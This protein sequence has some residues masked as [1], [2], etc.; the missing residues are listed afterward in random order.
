MP[1]LS[2]SIDL[3][4]VV[5]EVAL[6]I[7][8]LSRRL[9]SRF[10][11]FFTYLLLSTIGD[12]SALVWSWN[13][14]EFY[15]LYLVRETV[16]RALSLLVV[17]SIFS[18][19][20]R[21]VL[22]KLGKIGTSLSFLSLL[23]LDFLFWRFYHRALRPTPLGRMAVGVYTFELCV[24]VLEVAVCL[25]C[26]WLRRRYG[27][28]GEYDL[29]IIIGFGTMSM[30][31]IAAYGLPF[32]FGRRFDLWFQLIPAASFIGATISWLMTFS[33]PEAPPKEPPNPE[34]LR[35]IIEIIGHWTREVES[36]VGR[37][38]MRVDSLS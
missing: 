1:N 4:A 25:V 16:T 24:S 2:L 19:A 35:E 38:G 32:L 9:Q 21:F 31:T 12:L 8:L 36:V 28:W 27:V 15:V 26:L 13:V 20:L 5:L 10:A 29:G 22:Y 33:Q 6:A 7:V 14:T 3:T 37:L 30:G 18:P 17:L 23:V 34:K 11:L